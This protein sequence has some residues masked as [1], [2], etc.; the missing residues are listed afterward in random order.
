MNYTTT[1]ALPLSIEAAIPIVK[2]ALRAQGFGTLTEID[3]KSTLYEKIGEDFEPY[4]IL[5]ACNPRLAFRALSAEREIGALL[6]CNV[7]VR[8]SEGGVTVDALDPAIMAKVTEN[9]ELGPIAEEAALLIG[10]ALA[11]L[12][13]RVAS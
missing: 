13:E 6:P 10:E 4:V 9:P 11:G 12:K 5:G 1:V 8:Q 7:V 3:V 2:E